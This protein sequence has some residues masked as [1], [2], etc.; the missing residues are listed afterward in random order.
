[1]SSYSSS[2][3]SSSDITSSSG[4]SRLKPSSSSNA[5]D[6]GFFD[7]LIDVEEEIVEEITDEITT[8]NAD[9]VVYEILLNKVFEIIPKYKESANEVIHIGDFNEV[10]KA[11]NQVM[12]LLIMQEN[13]QHLE[14]FILFPDFLS[15][16]YINSLF[17]IPAIKNA[18]TKINETTKTLS[19]RRILTLLFLYLRENTGG[20]ESNKVPERALYLNVI[21]KLISSSSI[22]E[23]FSSTFDKFIKEVPQFY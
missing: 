2:R 15:D 9:K 16:E 17:N 8:M 12:M 6:N 19:V 7:T 3:A 21:N 14:N 10:E 23:I 22:N 11:I 4:Y 20:I 13:P 1:M 5:N 18:F